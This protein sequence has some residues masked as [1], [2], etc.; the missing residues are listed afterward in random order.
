MRLRLDELHAVAQ[1]E[2]VDQRVCAHGLDIAF[3]AARAADDDESRLRIAERGQRPNRNVGTLER[4]DAPDEQEHRSV[5]V[6]SERSTRSGLITRSEERVLDAWGD[7]L[8]AALWVAVVEAELIGFLVA[9]HAD[10]VSAVHD[11]GLGTITPWRFGVPMRGLHPSKGVECGD[12]RH[13]E[14]VLQ[15]MPDHAAEPVVAVDHIRTFVSGDPIEHT[16]TELVGHLRQRLFGEMMRTGL[17]VHHAVPWLD[18]DLIG[19]T[20][21]VGPSEGGGLDAC[22]GE[23]RAQFADVHIHA[24]AVTGT[25]LQQ[26]GGVEGDH[27]GALHNVADDNN[28]LRERRCRGT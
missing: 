2:F 23:R 17:D 1:P 27:R 4:L 9:T 26:R 25:R 24:A 6:E 7:D 5:E 11:L 14:L 10:G 8:E 28:A 13:V 19:E 3:D 21:P 15:P 18:D 16:V 22:L 20:G 12:E